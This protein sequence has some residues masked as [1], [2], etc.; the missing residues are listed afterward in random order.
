MASVVWH[1]FHQYRARGKVQ[2]FEG[3]GGYASGEQR[4]DFVSIDDVVQVNL[5]FLDHSERSGI[6]NLGSGEAATFNAVASATINACRAAEGATPLP[7]EA[8]HRA[9]AIEYIA[10]PAGLA[11]KYQSYTEADLSRLRA[12]GYA[13][14]MADI[15][16]GVAKCV[17]SLLAQ[18]SVNP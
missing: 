7:F 1:F 16:H 8:L 11:G 15:E 4:R 18:S 9:G 5:D 12:A 14:P 2:L 6:F 13:A 10:F 17:K 3:S